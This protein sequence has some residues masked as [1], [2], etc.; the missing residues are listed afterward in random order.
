MGTASYQPG[1]AARCLSVGM[2]GKKARTFL[3]ELQKEQWSDFVR[4]YEG[5]SQAWVTAQGYPE[6]ASWKLGGWIA[7]LDQLKIK[8][9]FFW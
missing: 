7:L 1:S 6:G 5:S 2:M 4:V 8:D 3:P 9:S